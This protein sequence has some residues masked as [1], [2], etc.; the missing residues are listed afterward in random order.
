[1]ASGVFVTIFA[2]LHLDK[3]AAKVLVHGLHTSLCK[4]Y[5]A[6]KFLGS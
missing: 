6:V 4:D 5:P 1:M 2:P 3:P